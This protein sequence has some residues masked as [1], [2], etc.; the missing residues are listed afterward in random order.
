MKTNFDVF[1]KV[2][3]SKMN[4]HIF[5][6]MRDLP[7]ITW[8]KIDAAECYDERYLINVT[9]PS[10]WGNLTIGAAI[11]YGEYDDGEAYSMLHL[12]VISNEDFITYEVDDFIEFLNLWWAEDGNYEDDGP[13]D[14]D[15]V[16]T[17]VSVC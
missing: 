1:M 4:Y 8:N 11:M 2:I 16:A 13:K 7:T 15:P 10:G 6:N 17:E 14:G 3:I 12:G 5:G 9:F